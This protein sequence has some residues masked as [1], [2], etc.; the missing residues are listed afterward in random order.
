MRFGASS[1]VGLVREVN[2]DAV[3]VL[4]EAGTL[5]VADGLGGHAAGEVASRLAV[6]TLRARLAG[7]DTVPDDEVGSRLVAALL[8]ASE[9]VADA[10]AQDPDRYGMGTTAVTAHLRRGRAW[11]AHVG[12]SRA[13]RYGGPG[14]EQLTRD[15]GSGS[16]LL[17]ALGL[18]D[19]VPDVA[20]LD[21][22]QGDRLLL[23]TD[24]L[25][26]TTDEAEIA[27]LVAQGDPQE[28]CDALVAAA[29][30]GGGIDNV[31]VA[32]AEAEVEAEEAP[33][34]APAGERGDR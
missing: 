22:A 25:T 29:L 7:L 33:L 5:L 19:V 31:T 13:Y 2:E 17:Q 28:A 24:G 9:A 15:H 27:R 16:L 12:D 10:A 18:G 6:D 20:V 21:L 26:D 11:V 3:A 1:D 4:P 34:T 14:L 8:A 30:R 23:C 32:V